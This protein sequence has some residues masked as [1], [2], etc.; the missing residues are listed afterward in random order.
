MVQRAERYFLRCEQGPAKD[1]QGNSFE[2][3][4]ASQLNLR[5]LKDEDDVNVRN[6]KNDSQIDVKEKLKFVS[7]KIVICYFYKDDNDVIFVAAMRYKTCTRL[8]ESSSSVENRI[9]HL[10]C[11]GVGV[12]AS[13]E[14]LTY[15]PACCLFIVLKGSLNSLNNPSFFPTSNFAFCF[16]SLGHHIWPLQLTIS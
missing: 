15:L 1:R 16:R 6:E 8:F 10:V 2:E 3:H 7:R 4:H 11:C 14:S 9:L 13:L 5:I 12:L